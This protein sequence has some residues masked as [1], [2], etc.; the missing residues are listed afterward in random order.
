[1]NRRDFNTTAFLGMIGLTTGQSVLAQ[2]LSESRA[3][4]YSMLRSQDGM[5]LKLYN[6]QFAT[7][8]KDQDQFILT[9]DVFKQR[10]LLTE[11]IYELVDEHGNKHAIFMTPVNHNQLQAVFNH[12]THA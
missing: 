11:R 9:F 1:M 6:K 5:L 2:S 3:D 10:D 7:A 8:D 12:R 4:N